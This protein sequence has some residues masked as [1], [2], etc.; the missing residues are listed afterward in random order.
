MEKKR[1]YLEIECFFLHLAH[2]YILFFIYSI[3]LILIYIKLVIKLEKLYTVLAVLKI[4]QKNLQIQLYK[5]KILSGAMIKH[6]HFK[7]V[8][9]TDRIQS[10]F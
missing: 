8:F 10:A 5:I 4:C 2:I 7:I 9:V 3:Y 6:M 1:V